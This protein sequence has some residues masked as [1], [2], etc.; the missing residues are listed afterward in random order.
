MNEDTIIQII[1]LISGLYLMYG[2]I[3]TIVSRQYL[4]KKEGISSH[5]ADKEYKK[6]SELD[7]FTER[8][9]R[10]TGWLFF[11]IALVAIAVYLF[12]K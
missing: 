8:Y 1:F 6:M 2:G 3:R 12:F 7:R 9:F 4:M 10:P 11:G 5:E